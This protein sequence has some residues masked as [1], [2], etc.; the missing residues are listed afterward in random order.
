M[1]VSQA[2]REFEIRCYYWHVAEFEKEI[3]S[4]YPNLRQ[5]KSGVGWKLYHF[6]RR[7]DPPSQLGFAHAKLKRGSTYLKESSEI[8][9]EEENRILHSFNEFVLQPSSRELEILEAKKTGAKVKLAS[10]TKLRKTV[11]AKMLKSFGSK[12][13]DTK[14]NNEWDPQFHTKCCGWIVNTQ[15]VVGRPP[16]ILWYR[17]MVESEKRLDHPSYPQFKFPTL[18]LSS[19]VAW[20]ENRWEDVLDEEIEAVSEA[21]VKHVGFFYEVAP[22]LLKGLEFDRVNESEPS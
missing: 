4:D 1:L 6:A 20:L 5:F 19:G 14:L 8:L 21:L 2:K 15:I 18:T 12:C 3:A 11:I 16:G 17:H 10:K 22:K 7:L 13:V 9:T